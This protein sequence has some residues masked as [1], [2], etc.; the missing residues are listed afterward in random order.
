MK[1]QVEIKI[2]TFNNKLKGPTFE[3]IFNGTILDRQINYLSDSYENCFNILPKKLNKLVIKHINKSPKDT[4]VKD[5]NIVGDVAL[6]LDDLRFNN[7]SCHPV[8][9]HEN[10]FYPENWTNDTDEKIKNNLYF[11]FNGR[12]EYCF[13]SPVTKF[14]LD[15]REKYTKEDFVL[16]RLDEYSDEKF[17]KLLNQHIEK[18]TKNLL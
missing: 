15:Q 12:Y 5:G 4:L 16:E 10:Y 8:D 11:G 14:V 9:L 7:I 18:E 17:V 1:E 6:R 13:E 2:S 3:I